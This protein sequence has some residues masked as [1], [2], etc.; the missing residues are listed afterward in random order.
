MIDKLKI[1]E[2]FINLNRLQR[3]TVLITIVILLVVK[4]SGMFVI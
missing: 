3:V 4:P 1:T 2:R